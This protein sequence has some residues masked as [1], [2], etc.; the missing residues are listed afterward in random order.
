MIHYLHDMILLHITRK[1]G[2][3]SALVSSS[4]RAHVFAPIEY[5][6]PP[7]KEYSARTRPDSCSYQLVYCFE[8]SK[9]ALRIILG[10][11]VTSSFLC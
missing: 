10:D 9:G 6:M 4:T 1:V 3:A 11:R 5:L 7:G 2:R 8:A